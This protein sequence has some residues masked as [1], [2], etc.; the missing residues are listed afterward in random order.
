MYGATLAVRCARVVKV[1][2]EIEPIQNSE[3]SAVIAELR[4]YITVMDSK[5][6]AADD[7]RAAA[8]KQNL[9]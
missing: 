4:K 3:R 8:A 9:L 5:W 6:N 7:V 2:M 1:L